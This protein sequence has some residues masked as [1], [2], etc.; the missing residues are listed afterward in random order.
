MV[1]RKVFFGLALAGSLAS[2][3]MT[4]PQAQAAGRGGFFSRLLSSSN[5][6]YTN[7]SNYRAPRSQQYSQPK[8]YSGYRIRSAP[9]G[10]AYRDSSGRYAPGSG[11]SFG[12]G[13][14]G[15]GNY[16]RSAGR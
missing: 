5:S 6:V 4:A 12:P 10:I 8:S 13:I 7:R 11:P 14:P 1:F 9:Y 2:L 15:F 3:S 16:A